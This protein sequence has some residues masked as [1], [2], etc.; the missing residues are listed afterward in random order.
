MA[1]E[2]AT[3]RASRTAAE[4][5]ATGP[6]SIQPEPS[7]QSMTFRRP[8]HRDPERPVYVISVAAS[9]VS[10]H[11]RILRIYEEEGL[12]CPAPTRTNIRLY[13]ENDFRRVMW[14]RPPTQNLGANLAG[15]RILFELEDRLGT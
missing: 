15:V 12:I 2:P 4:P 3:S 13:S 6:K 8:D 7:E 9:I 11:P 14:I 5:A 10:V 1:S